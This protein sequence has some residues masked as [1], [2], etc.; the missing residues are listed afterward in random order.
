MPTML[1]AT[2]SVRCGGGELSGSGV[3]VGDGRTVVTNYHVVEACGA[4][5]PDAAVIV[6]GQNGEQRNARIV[7]ARELEDLAVLRVDGVLGARPVSLRSDAS[8]RPG[9]F[10]W[11]LGYPGAAEGIGGVGDAEARATFGP[12]SRASRAE[13]NGARYV[14]DHSAGIL[15]G[16]SGGPL[17]D[18]CGAVVGINTYIAVAKGQLLGQVGYAVGSRTI[19]EVVARSGQTLTMQSDTCGAASMGTL[20]GQATETPASAKAGDGS[21]ARKLSAS[22]AAFAKKYDARFAALQQE[23]AAG[24]SA[25]LSSMEESADRKVA[26]LAGLLNSLKGDVMS[27]GTGDAETTR[28][29]DALDSQLRREQQL[30][31][32]GIGVALLLALAALWYAVRSGKGL[33]VVDQKVREVAGAVDDVK[34][35]L[36][37]LE[38]SLRRE[39]KRKVE[40]LSRSDAKGAADAQAVGA[41]LSRMGDLSSAGL[42]QVARTSIVRTTRGEKADAR[43]GGLTARI[44]VTDA[45]GK[46]R[47]ASLTPG[48]AVYIG[49]HK[50]TME[51]VAKGFVVQPAFLEVEQRPNENMLSR[52]HCLIVNDGF[53]VHVIDASTNGTFV[54]AP[55]QP[56]IT[57]GTEVP[58]QERRNKPNLLEKGDRLDVGGATKLSLGRPDSGYEVS[59]VVSGTAEMKTHVIRTARN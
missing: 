55:D 11:A 34:D 22:Y 5:E 13:G 38:E 26:D 44:E 58:A 43:A 17:F 12:V 30:Q 53:D 37:A 54:V 42:S 49:R 59:V 40:E 31:W 47:A 1:Q 9:Q 7:V 3:V 57:R 21:A 51:A 15:P 39:G 8:V 20:V 25:T 6:R 10:V 16:N 35:R 18:A 19:N 32:V 28:R 23:I 27:N 29:I 24:D 46:S 41:M 52:V 48:S 4:T 56:A 45:N 33:S 14:I 50:P 2:V 36:D